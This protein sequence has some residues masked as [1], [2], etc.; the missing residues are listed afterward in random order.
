MI[1]SKWIF[2]DSEFNEAYKIRKEVFI[3]E[4]GLSE[5]IHFDEYDKRALHVLIGE[6]GKYLATGRLYEDN[7][8][9]YIGGIAVLPEIRGKKVGD[10]L[11]RLLINKAFDFFAKEIF[12]YARLESVDFYKKLNF[13]ECSKVYENEPGDKRIIMKVIKENSPLEHNCQSCGKCKH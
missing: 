10:L 9:F 7:Q 2:G 12:V 11:V 3:D 8:K 6:D 4:L 13:I 1:E 5:A